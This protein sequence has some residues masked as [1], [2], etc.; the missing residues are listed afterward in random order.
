[1]TGWT[2][3]EPVSWKRR[4]KPAGG[5]GLSEDSRTGG[6]RVWEARFLDKTKEYRTSVQRK[7]QLEREWTALNTALL[8]AEKAVKESREA[9]SIE[10]PEL[11]V[12]IPRLE[13]AM[14]LYEQWK[15]KEES[16]LSKKKEEERGENIFNP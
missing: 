3:P 13:E 1:M 8:E 16:Y 6:E 12:L 10:I 4:K 9:S 5:K 7:E 2:R 11:S 15:E 14:P